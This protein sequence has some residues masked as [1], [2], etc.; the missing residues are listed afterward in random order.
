MTPAKVKEIFGHLVVEKEKTR[1]TDLKEFPRYV[2]EYLIN[3]F[4][5]GIDF[6]KELGK[7]RQHL[8]M[9]RDFSMN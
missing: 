4:C 5:P 7:V 3:Q 2:L 1:L 8:L 9:H 6:D